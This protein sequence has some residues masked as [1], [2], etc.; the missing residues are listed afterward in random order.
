[1]L[2]LPIL[3]AAGGVNSAG[4]TSHRHGFKRMVIDSLPRETQLDTHKALA[5]MMGI[6]DQAQQMAG[7]LI[8]G[9]EPDYFAEMENALE[10]AHD[11][12]IQA[13]LD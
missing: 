4:R 11:L 3:V 6:S 8:R 9:I 13:V 7:T 5:A 1:M 12:A 10:V 2:R